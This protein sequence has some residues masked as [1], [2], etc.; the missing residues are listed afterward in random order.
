MKVVSKEN[1]GS[2]VARLLDLIKGKADRSHTHAA[3]DVA[4]GT[5][6]AERLP[7]VPLSRG[8][9]GATD[10]AGAL[11]AIGAA[12]SGHA[13]DYLPLAG[14]T[15]TG[16]VSSR[17]NAARVGDSPSSS[18][19][20]NALAMKDAGGETLAN[21][22]S[23]VRADGRTGVYVDTSREVGGTRKYNSLQMLL[24]AEGNPSYALTSPSAFRSAI[25]AAAADHAHKA[26]VSSGYLVGDASAAASGGS[27]VYW[28]AKGGVAYV[29]ANVQRDVAGSTSWSLGTVSSG[30]R[31]A[32]QVVCP[33]T[34]NGANAG[35]GAMLRLR[36]TGALTMEFGVKSV[37]GSAS[38]Y[39]PAHQVVCPLTENG[40]NAGSGAMLRLRQTGALTMEFGVK[41]VTGS[42]WYSGELVWFYE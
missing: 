36:Q 26:L 39:R 33:L 10:A 24:D 17:T 2:I 23:V 14:G 40:A 3:S 1:A 20:G 31:P 35:S 34:E 4:S 42:A 6:A 19:Y 11:R 32:H 18:S 12:A 38:G 41:S 13:H 21:V 8:G 22:E 27:Y 9:T 37:T 5:L 15:L 7:T 29:I 30:Y 25:S 16:T 28:A